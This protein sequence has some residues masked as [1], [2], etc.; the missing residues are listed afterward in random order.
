MRAMMTMTMTM[1]RTTMRI[2]PEMGCGAQ[3]IAAAHGLVFAKPGAAQ[4][5]Y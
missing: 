5:F 3:G 2:D 4:D 1:M